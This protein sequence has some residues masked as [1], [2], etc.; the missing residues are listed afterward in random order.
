MGVEVVDH[1]EGDDAGGGRG[2]RGKGDGGRER[3]EGKGRKGKE[4]RKKEGGLLSFMISNFVLICFRV[5][6]LSISSA[7]ASI[8]TVMTHNSIWY[9]TQHQDWF[10]AVSTSRR[11][12]YR[13]YFA[14]A[15]Q[16]NLNCVRT[17]RILFIER[18]RQD[19]NFVTMTKKK[20]VC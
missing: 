1:K 7:V 17:R 3:I 11:C 19:K 4:D 14:G 5:E 12:A 20:S 10:L 6:D 15:A 16:P 8:Y 13:A 2:L 18:K 9:R